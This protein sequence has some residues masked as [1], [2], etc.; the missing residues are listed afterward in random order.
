MP[1]PGLATL[2]V[3]CGEGRVARDLR[4]RGHKVTAID[5]SPSLIAAARVSDPASTYLVARAEELPFA[6][7]TFDAAVAYNSLM[8]V[9][10][11]PAALLELARVLVPGGRLAV[12]VT[13]PLHDSGAF[14]GGEDEATFVIPGTYFGRRK[15]SAHVSRGGRE[16][17]FDGFAYDLESYSRSLEAGGLLIE[18]VREP[19]PASGSAHQSRIPNFLM[20]RALKPVLRAP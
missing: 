4:D 13:H 10:D 18:L 9:D 2:E 15:F 11:M 7:S 14:S 3:G 1:A 17:D 19:H 6:D 16:M 5:A 20:W 8:D 12:S